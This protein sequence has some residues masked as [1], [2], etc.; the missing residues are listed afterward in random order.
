[1]FHQD[2]QTTRSGLKK[3]RRRRV[4]LTHFEVIGYLMKHPFKFFIW[5]LKPFIILEEIQSKRI[6]R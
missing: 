5:L 4:F 6:L 2:I 1:M 3:M